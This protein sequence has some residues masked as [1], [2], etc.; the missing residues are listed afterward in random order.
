MPMSSEVTTVLA[1]RDFA[2]R[3]NVGESQVG[4]ASQDG[5]APG[6]VLTRSR[7]GVP[8]C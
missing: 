2:I 3:H 8:R 5:E 6:R 1:G 7:G 4:F